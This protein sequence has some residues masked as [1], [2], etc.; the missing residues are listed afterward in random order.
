MTA[1]EISDLLKE[2]FGDK[3]LE[4]HEDDLS[5]WTKI[6]R[7]SLVEACT[8]WRD[9]AG[10]DMKVCHDLTVVDRLQHFERIRCRLVDDT[11]TDPLDSV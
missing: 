2:R 7:G 11:Q 3:I 9:D 4:V 6:D 10:A 8:F 5:A 1:T